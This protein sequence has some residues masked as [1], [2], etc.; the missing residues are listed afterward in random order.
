ML[1]LSSLRLNCSMFLIVCI[2]IIRRCIVFL[3]EIYD[4]FHWESELGFGC[5]ET[6]DLG[7]SLSKLGIGFVEIFDCSFADISWYSFHWPGNVLDGVFA[8]CLV[9]DVSEEIAW[10]CKVAVRMVG[11]VTANESSHMVWFITSISVELKGVPT[12]I[13]LAEWV[14]LIVGFRT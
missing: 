10:L 7:D 14:R 11:L 6:K 12:F 5:T 9:H 1:F 8:H 2:M 4:W 13:E 3:R